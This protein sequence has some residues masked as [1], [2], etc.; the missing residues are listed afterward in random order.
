[1]F[2]ET[3]S[4]WTFVNFQTLVFKIF[5]FRKT[6]CWDK[7]FRS[8]CLRVTVVLLKGNF[9][10]VVLNCKN[11]STLSLIVF[12]QVSFTKLQCRSQTR[13]KVNIASTM[14]DCWVTCYCLRWNKSR[15]FVWDFTRTLLQSWT[16]FSGNYWTKNNVYSRSFKLGLLWCCPPCGQLW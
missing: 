4:N 13:Q 12:E 2:T 7:P 8:P 10:C 15:L 16:T 11:M 3:K 9:K 6:Q 14:K 5:Y 1:V